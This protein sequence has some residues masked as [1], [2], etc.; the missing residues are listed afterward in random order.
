[1]N[2]NKY[3]HVTLRTNGDMFNTKAMRYAFLNIWRTY[4][5]N[6]LQ[7][8]TFALITDRFECILVTSNTNEL[9]SMQLNTQIAELFSKNCN[10]IFDKAQ[11]AELSQSILVES[12]Y[13]EKDMVYR[14]FDMH[15]MPQR[16]GFTT[17]YRTYP[18]SSYKSLT[19]AN[20]SALAKQNVW[21]WF[22]GRLRFTAFHQAYA[23]WLK[24][25]YYDIAS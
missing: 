10:P 11:I 16:L 21:N 25:P 12:L 3:F 1:M 9:N 22:G 23:G 4:I 2:K 17:D 15:T 24:S 5:P 14:A 8:C 18:F 13:S 19:G 7:T 6:H 20:S